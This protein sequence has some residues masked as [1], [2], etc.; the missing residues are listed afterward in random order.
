MA[1]AIDDTALKYAMLLT[2]S[3]SIA[4]AGT[5]ASS[6]NPQAICAARKSNSSPLTS[7]IA[8]TATERRRLGVTVPSSRSVSRSSVGLMAG[9]KKELL[10]AGSAAAGGFGSL[11]TSDINTSKWGAVDASV[12]LSQ[13]PVAAGVPP[14]AGRILL[15]AGCLFNFAF[16]LLNRF[17]NAAVDIQLVGALHVLQSKPSP[18]Q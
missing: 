14:C 10:I 6:L 4:S 5:S 15:A 13:R 17:F 7:A 8:R 18:A 9:Q 2:L 3:P 16:Q 12:E 1:P 11:I